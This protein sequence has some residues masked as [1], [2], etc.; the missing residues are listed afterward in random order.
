MTVDETMTEIVRRLESLSSIDDRLGRIETKM[1]RT[2]EALAEVR[3]SVGVLREDMTAVRT[4]LWQAKWLTLLVGNGR[5]R[6]EGEGIEPHRWH[7]G[8]PIGM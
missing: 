2:V 5:I 3:A 4:Q 8:R 7:P 6:A 1:D